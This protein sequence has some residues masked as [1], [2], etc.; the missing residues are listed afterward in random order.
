M[1]CVCVC[2]CVCVSAINQFN[3]LSTTLSKT[4]CH[5]L[6]CACGFCFLLSL[7]NSYSKKWPNVDSA[8]MQEPCVPQIWGSGRQ[9]KSYD[10][11][12]SL[13]LI[14]LI[15]SP[16]FYT[17]TCNVY[18]SGNVW[19]RCQTEIGTKVNRSLTSSRPHNGGLTTL[20]VRA[21]DTF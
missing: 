2:V 8:E 16:Q 18:T 4:V 7:Q 15:R 9:W 13:V 10:S 21:A 20:P 12:V 11:R 17:V 3:E 14:N 19:Y 5:V 1:V 6:V